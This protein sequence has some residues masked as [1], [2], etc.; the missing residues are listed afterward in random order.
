[1]RTLLPSLMDGLPG[2]FAL[3]SFS[4]VVVARHLELEGT[5]TPP[6]SNTAPPCPAS[7]PVL[8]PATGRPAAF[9]K[10]APGLRGRGSSSPFARERWVFFRGRGFYDTSY[11]GLM[12]LALQQGINSPAPC[13]RWCR[14]VLD[15]TAFYVVLHSQSQHSSEIPFR[16]RY[17]LLLCCCCC[18]RCMGV[19]RAVGCCQCQS[20]T[21]IAIHISPSPSPLAPRP[22]PLALADIIYARFLHPSI[23]FL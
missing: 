7:W 9:L 1:M 14:Y 4:A 5:E 20:L 11:F 13:L 15:C 18:C 2:I 21:D 23:P 19:S 8:C 17:F 10:S 3:F 16:A 22:L 12:F 6:H